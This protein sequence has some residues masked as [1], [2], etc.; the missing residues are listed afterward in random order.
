MRHNFVPIAYKK[1][2]P[3]AIRLP[4]ALWNYRNGGMISPGNYNFQ[5]LSYAFRHLKEAPAIIVICEAKGWNKADG[6]PFAHVLRTVSNCFGVPYEGKIGYISRGNFGPAILFDTRRLAL[7]YW[8]DIA[9]ADADDKV[10]LARFIVRGTDEVFAVLPEHWDFRSGRARMPYAERI[11]SYGKKQMRVL[12]AGDLNESASGLHLPQMDWSVATPEQLR[13]KGKQ[14]PDGTWTTHT[15]AVD[16]LVGRWDPRFKWGDEGARR[17][18]SGRFNM[19]AE[20]A[21][22]T[23]TPLNEAFMATGRGS[24]LLIDMMLI[25][26]V[27]LRQ[28]QGSLVPGTYRVIGAN[29]PHWPSDHL[30]VS[31]VLWV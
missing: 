8:G 31:A 22:G 17:V 25:N 1:E 19:L 6:K 7:S 9:T 30:L 27:W 29:D 4:V 21:A 5:G 16:W 11:Q 15:D 20:I 14:L 28:K 10:N 2:D 12:V 26:D 24:S 13:H 3:L 18:N 23:G